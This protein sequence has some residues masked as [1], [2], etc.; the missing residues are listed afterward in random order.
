MKL[1]NYI[2]V[3]ALALG[4]SSQIQAFGLGGLGNLVGGVTS[5]GGANAGQ[6]IDDF[7]KTADEA[8][9]LTSKSVQILA[10]A[11]LTKEANDKLKADMEAA[12]AIQDPKER[13]ANIRKVEADSLAALAKIDYEK[14]AK[15][16]EIEN[17][18][19][20]QAQV[21][22]SIYNFMLALL[23]DK[24]LVEKGSYLA[25]SVSSNPLLITKLGKV[26]D[27]VTS[28]SGQM[29]N[30]AKVASGLQKL[31]SVA[32]VTALPTKATDAP[33]EDTL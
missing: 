31:S 1:W 30:M 15:V 19:K 21:G 17:D 24:E 4:M 5:G 7:L 18:K 13:E 26:T 6:Q 29:G 25:S 20:K 10:D 32:K 23:K 3:A 16:K 8:H 14:N 28:I 33:K 12:K 9:A 27:V 11:L 2:G 22:A